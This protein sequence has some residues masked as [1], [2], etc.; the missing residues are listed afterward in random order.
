M[1]QKYKPSLQVSVIRWVAPQ[2][3]WVKCN[4]NGACKGNLGKSSYGSCVTDHQGNHNYVESNIGDRTN[5]TTEVR[6]IKGALTYYDRQELG[7]IVL[8][9][10][11]LSLKNILT[12]SCKIPWEIVDIVEEILD[13]MKSRINQIIHVVRE[14]NNLANYLSNITCDSE[15]KHNYTTFNQLP[16]M[17]K[18]ILNMDKHG[19]PSFRVKKR[20]NINN[21]SQSHS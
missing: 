18:R 8:E 19:I 7:L 3:G 11:S 13:I 21:I 15:E 2:I 6:A 4:P 1:L 5:T 9:T 17:E 12:K 20:N 14:A 16:S 10:D